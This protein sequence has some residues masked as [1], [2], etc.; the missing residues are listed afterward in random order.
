M[1]A[2][3]VT[4]GSSSRTFFVGSI[5]L[6]AFEGHRGALVGIVDANGEGCGKTVVDAVERSRISRQPHNLN[7]NRKRSKKM[8]SRVVKGVSAN[9]L[10]SAM[11]LVPKGICEKR[12][13]NASTGARTVKVVDSGHR[14]LTL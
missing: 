12:E 6:N 2:P 1:E 11:H 13:N 10:R 7:I 14:V 3:L 8:S 9:F 4:S 5:N